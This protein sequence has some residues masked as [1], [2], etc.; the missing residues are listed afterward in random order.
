MEYVT[1]E[2]ICK[3]SGYAENTVKML[4]VD[5]ILPQSC[6][7]RLKKGIYPSEALTRVAMYK[8]FIAAGI[9]KS[10]IVKRMTR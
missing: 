10:D 5:G 4:I 9:K 8:E 2:D 6:G 1:L 7:R 3:A